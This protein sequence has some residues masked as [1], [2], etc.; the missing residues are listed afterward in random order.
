[1]EK[2]SRFIKHLKAQKVKKVYIDGKEENRYSVSTRDGHHMLILF[3]G[4]GGYPEVYL[5]KDPD[6]LLKKLK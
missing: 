2:L 6:V 4:T 5:E 3:Q 1:M